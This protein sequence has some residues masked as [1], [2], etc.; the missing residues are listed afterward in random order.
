MSTNRTV[1]AFEH[2]E[3]R[4]NGQNV[5]NIQTVLVTIERLG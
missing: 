4:S 2:C 3:E 5:Q 1:I